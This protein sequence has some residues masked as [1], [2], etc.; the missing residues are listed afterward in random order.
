MHSDEPSQVFEAAA[1][2]FALLSAPMRLRV[3]CELCEG[4]R[5]VSDLL[6]RIETTQPNMSQHLSMMYRAGV[7][8]RRREGTQVFYRVRSERLLTV[9]RAVCEDLATELPADAPVVPQVRGTAF[10]N[11]IRRKR[12]ARFQ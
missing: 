8:D 11:P 3:M 4:E 5:N 12:G 9:C 6:A 10:Q 7:L 2:L 1:Q